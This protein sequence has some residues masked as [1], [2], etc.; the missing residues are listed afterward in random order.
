MTERMQKEA[1]ERLTGRIVN[2]G[3]KTNQYVSEEEARKKA[4]RV[5]KRYETN[6]QE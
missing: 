5:Q 4:I 6:K 1:I 2:H 3:R